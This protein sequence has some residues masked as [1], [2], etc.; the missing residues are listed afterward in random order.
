MEI[1]R[2]WDSCQ[3]EAGLT[4]MVNLLNTRNIR[5]AK[6][7]SSLLLYSKTPWENSR[8][9]FWILKL[10]WSTDNLLCSKG[11]FILIGR[12]VK[13]KLKKKNDL[14]GIAVL[15][16]KFKLLGNKHKNCSVRWVF[17][18]LLIWLLMVK[19]SPMSYCKFQEPE[20]YLKMNS[21]YGSLRYSYCH[22]LSL[23]H[24]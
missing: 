3:Y 24:Q 5:S 20:L 14:G 1:L 23:L 7:I 21:I 16:M 13:H 17:W 11:L 6:P 19:F 18:H 2:T 22:N 4:L 10:L 9:T 12:V 15:P 8:S